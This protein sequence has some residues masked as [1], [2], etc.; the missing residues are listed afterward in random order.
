M[1]IA[2]SLYLM[3][4]NFGGAMPYSGQTGSYF[5]TYHVGLYFDLIRTPIY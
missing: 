4:L 5:Y 1:F 2:K 3:S